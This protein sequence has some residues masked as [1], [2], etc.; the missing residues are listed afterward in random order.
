M[1]LSQAAMTLSV[2][3]SVNLRPSGHSMTPII[4]HRQQVTLT[5]DTDDDQFKAG[6]VVLVKV[7]GAWLL[8]RISKVGDGEFQIANARGKVN[9]W[10]RR[11]AIAGIVTKIH[12]R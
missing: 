12:P 4:H 9:G 1:N 11:T 2:G 10:V 5:P 3:Q 8:H 6:A 7:R